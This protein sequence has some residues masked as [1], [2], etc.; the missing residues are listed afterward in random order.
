MSARLTGATLVNAKLRRLSRNAASLL[1]LRD[2]DV[3]F[4][5]VDMQKANDLT[6]GIMALVAQA[7]RETTYRRTK[8]ALAVAMACGVKLGNSN[9]AE[10]RRRPR[11]GAAVYMQRIVLFSLHCRRRLQTQTDKYIAGAER[12]FP[13]PNA[14]QPLNARPVTITPQRIACCGTSF[15]TRTLAHPPAILAQATTN[16]DGQ[17]TAPETINTITARPCITQASTFFAAFS[18]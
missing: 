3:H 12:Q 13:Y 18:R 1:P 5:A 10:A 14:Y 11:N 9:G 4:L 7:G 15:P 8:E 17:S 2:S 16:T 6:L